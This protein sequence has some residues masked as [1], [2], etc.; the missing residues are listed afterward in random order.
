MEQCDAGMNIKSARKVQGENA[1]RSKT[2]SRY[3]LKGNRLF[4]W[5]K[6]PTYSFL[7]RHKGHRH[8]FPLGIPNKEAAARL[9]AGICNDLFTLGWDATLTK[10]KPNL[11]KETASDRVANIGEWIDAAHRVSSVNAS[12]FISYARALRK[13]AGD[14]LVV[15]RTKKRFGPRKGGAAGYRAAIDSASLDILTLSGLQQWRLEYV[16]RAKTPAEESSRM[17]S[18]NSTIRQARSLFAAKIVKFLPDLRLPDPAPFHAVE[19]FPRQSAKYFSRIDAKALLQEARADLSENDS[20]TFIAIL[21]AIGAGLRRG[22][23]DSLQW[24]Q[25]DFQRQLIR[26][27]ITDAASLKTI[28]ARDEVGIDEHIV[29]ILRGFHARRTGEFVV[30]AKGMKKKTAVHE[31]LPSD[32]KP[33][34]V[35]V[36]C[37][38]KKWGQHYRAGFVLD[39]GVAW[40]RKHGVTARKPLHELRK[41]LGAIF[42][43]EHGIY[44]ASRVMRHSDVST[45]ARHYSDLKTR[46]VVNIGGWLTEGEK[47]TEFPSQDKT[48]VEK[49]SKSRK[50][51]VAK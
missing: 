1:T 16:K 2:D 47:V 35:L 3:W 51:K 7:I 4:K 40:L 23:I 29:G 50:K 34:K 22:E 48:K 15:K 27:E 25:V 8:S 19:F 9:A 10:H 21:L 43:A 46:P 41:E 42:T 14:L 11:A 44:A 32:K 30:E 49:P 39:K 38:P 13:I 26:V 33:E 5:Q 36:G 17:T 37:G 28:D 24:H 45:T 20:P 18:C 6:S 12:T 31:P